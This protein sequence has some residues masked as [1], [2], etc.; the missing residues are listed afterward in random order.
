VNPLLLAGS[1]I[2]LGSR[3]EIV[4]PEEEISRLRSS[5]QR[6]IKELVAWNRTYFW[7]N[8]DVVR[9]QVIFVSYINEISTIEDFAYLLNTGLISPEAIAR[10]QGL[11]PE[12]EGNFMLDKLIKLYSAYMAHDVR[13]PI[14]HLAGP[15]GVGKSAVVAQLGDLLGVKV[16]TVNVSRLSPLEIEG[17]QMP[18]VDPDDDTKQKLQLLHNTLWTQLREGDIVLLDEFLRGFPEVYNGLLDIM[19]SREVAGFKLPKVFFVA[20]SNSTSA[21]DEALRD[22]LLHILVPDIRKSATAE[23][24]ARRILIDSIG[25]NPECVDSS[26]ARVLMTS[27]VKPMYEMLDQFAGSGRTVGAS[28]GTGVGHSIRNLIGQALLR[29][30]SSTALRDLI[31]YNN[32]ISIQ[33]KK[34]QFVLLLNGKNPDPKYVDQARKLVG[35]EKLSPLQAANLKLNLELIEMEEQ[36]KSTHPSTT[37]TKENDELDEDIF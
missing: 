26:E 32:L 16:H 36:R 18:I 20:A 29:E 11:S 7:A 27:E 34:A 13:S 10:T 35:N 15:P 12:R 24:H 23:E 17:V 5:A 6:R 1:Q 25:L 30:V 22:R 4:V 9:K 21:Y 37:T 3:R 2:T 8:T 33:N 14:P 28:A 31:S 19:T